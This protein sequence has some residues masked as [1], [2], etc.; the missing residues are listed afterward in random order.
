M[1]SPLIVRK[2]SYF[3]LKLT[4]LLD[5][6]MSKLDLDKSAY[7]DLTEEK[8]VMQISKIQ[9]VIAYAVNIPSK[10]KWDV[11]EANSISKVDS[12]KQEVTTGSRV[13]FLLSIEDIV[14]YLHYHNW[15]PAGSFIILY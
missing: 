11:V 15:L 14:Y 7:V 9:D 3:T 12:Q 4:N 13:D 1:S 10:V 2:N 6:F 5:F 8:H